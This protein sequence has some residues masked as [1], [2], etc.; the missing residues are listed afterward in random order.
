MDVPEGRANVRAAVGAG[1]RGELR[2]WLAPRAAL[3]FVAA[4][5]YSPRPWAGRFA[6]EGL[7]SEPFPSPTGR[8]LLGV[9]LGVLAFP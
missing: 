5:D 4:A 9:S 6:I 1:A 2:L 3:S 7:G 8:L